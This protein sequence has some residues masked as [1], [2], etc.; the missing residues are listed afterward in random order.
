MAYFGY[1]N[2]STLDIIIHRKQ[3]RHK[4]AELKKLLVYA[5]MYVTI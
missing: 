1:N 5:K 2:L 4:E 3:Q